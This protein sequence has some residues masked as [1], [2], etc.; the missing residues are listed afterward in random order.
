VKPA[1]SQPAWAGYPTLPDFPH[2]L[3]EFR[4]DRFEL[5]VVDKG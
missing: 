1:K 4:T 3:L 5:G 2:G